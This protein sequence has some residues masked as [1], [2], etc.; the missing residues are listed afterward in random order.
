MNGDLLAT[1]VAHLLPGYAAGTLDPAERESVRAHLPTCAD[2]RAEL[3]AWQAIGQAA[4][5]A[6][7]MPIPTDGDALDAL[8]QR[9][10]AAD[11]AEGFRPGLEGSVVSIA[12]PIPIEPPR[13]A[14]GR[15]RR[16]LAQLATAALIVLTLAGSFFAVRHSSLQDR[17]AI[18]P[19]ISGTPAT[20]EAVRTE[21]LIDTTIDNLPAGHA[22]VSS[23]L[24]TLRPSPEPMVVPPLGG[25]SI[26]VVESGA[27]EAMVDGVEQQLT[28]GQSLR[29]PGDREA[30]I[31]AVGDE[32]ATAFDIDFLPSFS[33]AGRALGEAPN[34][35]ST[36]VYDPV[37]YTA[38]FLTSASPDALPGGSA[39]LVFE[40]LTLPP[41]SALPS[42]LPDPLAWTGVAEGVLG[43]TLDGERLP[44]RWQPGDER[45]FRHGQK[46][47]PVQ[48]GTRMTMRNA[49]AE[50]LT[51]YRLALVPDAVGTPPATP[52]TAVSGT[53]RT[54]TLIDADGVALPNGPATIYTVVTELR[55]GVSSVLDG[56]VGTLIYRVERGTLEISHSG[57][58]QV[59]AAGEQWG[60]PVNGE[61]AFRN[62]GNDDA[63]VV[64][65]DVLDA[66]ATFSLDANYAS[67]F[68]DPQGASDSFVIQV[69][70]DLPGGTG[71]ATLERLTLPPGAS[72][73]PYAKTKFD[74]IGVAAGRV[75]VTLQ[76]DRLPFR[77]D[78]GEERTFG[79]HQTMPVIPPG[80]EVTL[81]NAGDGE[82]VIYRLQLMPN[83]ST[84]PNAMPTVNGTPESE[85]TVETETLLDV[86]ADGLP[87][88]QEMIAVDRWRLS[89]SASEAVLPAHEGA[90]QLLV[91]SGEVTVSLDGIERRLEPGEAL[92][93]ANR[94]FGFRASGPGKAVAYVVYATPR[95]PGFGG[96][97]QWV[98]GD[99]LVHSHDK[100][101]T[102]SVDNF[103]GG[104]AQLVL[105]RIR[106]AS[107]GALPPQHASPLVWIQ[108]GSG[109]LG[110]TLEGDR[111]PYGWKPGTERRIF[112]FGREPIPFMAPGTTMLMRNAGDEPLVLYRL[113]LIPENAGPASGTPRAGTPQPP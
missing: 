23:R 41:G 76:G 113:S 90:V 88:G 48:P 46:L 68:S 33:G 112:Q 21:T 77:W 36:W 9:I 49:G 14:P 107:G 92:D 104:S 102:G 103:G 13:G 3:K 35:G 37:D 100:V 81:R 24:W 47:P 56:Q 80:T 15:G 18:L 61:A 16:A 30:T 69:G 72:L 51:L 99:P 83:G 106:V 10:E 43:L 93:V 1:H 22:I 91:D 44:F 58:Q 55:P 97:R 101:L 63:L 28:P 5:S 29:L 31:R 17:S 74:W 11:S 105:E 79:L 95:F 78:P 27:I 32:Q 73:D 6:Y 39:R 64:E 20:P 67:K 34:D 70:V 26:F 59:V 53:V 42:S 19:P 4:R 50:P 85:M 87:A 98:S 2:C 71:R 45:T 62:V 108:V 89:P 109:E 8:W 38:D 65:V 110:L 52:G 75:G 12:A 57:V 54:E 84:P 94:E 82:L 7:A 40:R 60:A 96:N 66:I 111:L 86:V 25:P